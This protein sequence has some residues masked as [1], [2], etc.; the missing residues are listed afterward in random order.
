M[1]RKR[2]PGKGNAGRGRGPAGD[3]PGVPD[4]DYL[5]D[6]AEANWPHILRMYRL[7]EDRRPVMLYDLQEGRVYAYPYP[8]FRAEM[9]ERSQRTLEDQYERAGREGKIVV[10]IRDNDARRLVSFSMAAE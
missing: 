2:R 7:F 5:L 3:R 9:G 1:G 6:A 10:F 4:S 8:E